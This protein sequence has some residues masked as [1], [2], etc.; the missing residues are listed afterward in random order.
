M[1]Q[2]LTWG[3]KRQAAAACLT[4]S[5]AEQTNVDPVP[6]LTPEQSLDTPEGIPNINLVESGEGALP[7]ELD[8]V[9]AEKQPTPLPN[10]RPELEGFFSTD[11]SAEEPA[12]ST[13]DVSRT[14]EEPAR[15]APDS[16]GEDSFGAVEAG[17]FPDDLD[18]GELL[19]RD[20]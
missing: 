14:P 6:T 5:A 3:S 18:I 2:H 13:E 1:S 8:E 20:F 12:E 4:P 15:G 17:A 10:D 11:A 16:V 7:F 9:N 19:L